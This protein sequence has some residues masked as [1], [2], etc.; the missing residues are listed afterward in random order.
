[1]GQS[2]CQIIILITVESIVA[3]E[4]YNGARLLHKDLKH[5]HNMILR[6]FGPNCVRCT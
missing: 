2:T 6:L 1:M 4:W 3:R 5:A